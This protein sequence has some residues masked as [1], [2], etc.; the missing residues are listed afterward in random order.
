M[1]KASHHLEA[2]CYQS[3]NPAEMESDVTKSHFDD[4]FNS[5]ALKKSWELARHV[6]IK[7]TPSVFR[8]VKDTTSLCT[9]DF[10]A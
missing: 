6:L 9:G 2:G 4:I 8:L 5:Y 7:F 3:C 10:K 1:K